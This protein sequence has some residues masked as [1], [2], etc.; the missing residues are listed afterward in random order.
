LRVEIVFV[1]H[2]VITLE[3]RPNVILRAADAVGSGRPRSD[4]DEL[5]NVIECLVAVESPGFSGRR[6]SRS[7]A[8]HK[9]AGP[10]GIARGV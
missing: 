7:R 4:R 1:N 8:I 2:A 10:A 3:L 5:R 9:Q 6:G